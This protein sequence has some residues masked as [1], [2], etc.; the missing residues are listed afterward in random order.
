MATRK[1]PFTRAR[2][3]KGWSFTEASQHMAGVAEQQLRNLEGIGATRDTDPSRI[4]F[5]TAME[6]TRAYWPSIQ[7][8]HFSPGALV[9]FRPANAT[10]RKKLKG[11]VVS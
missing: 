3:A 5:A 9:E 11:Y 10:A 6:I 7:A 4:R 2:E 1:N 8:R